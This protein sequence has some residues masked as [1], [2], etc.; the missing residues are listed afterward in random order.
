MQ[1][2]FVGPLGAVTG[3]CTWLEHEG[4]EFLVDCG[5]EQEDRP[6]AGWNGQ[7]WPF[8]P[9]QLSF[10]VLTHAHADHCGL[11]PELYRR[12]FHGR[13]LCTK[14]TAEIA[15]VMLTDSA[16][17]SNGRY[18]QFD[19]NAIQWKEPGR[20]MLGGYHP[21]AHDLFIQFFRTAH[22]IGAVSVRILW[23]D[24]TAGEQKSIIFSGDLG[25]D[26]EDQECLPFLRHRMGVP[27]SDFAVIEST[28]GSRERD[29]GAHG[30]DARRSHLKGLMDKIKETGGT[31]LIPA[32]SLGRTQDLLFDLHWLVAAN[33]KR[34]AQFVFRL[35][36]P[37]AEKLGPI[38]ANGLERTEPN[39]KGKIRP[40]WLGKQLFRWLGL[41]DAE[42]EDV[43]R[44][45]DICRVTLGLPIKYPGSGD[46]GNEIARGW[47]NLL[48][49]ITD[50]SGSATPEK[51]SKR[52]E[53]VVATSGMGDHGRSASWVRRLLRDPDSVIAFSG[54]CAASS[55]GGKLLTLAKASVSERRRSRENLSW[56]DGTSIP[57]RDVVAM[58]GAL[59]GYS[60]H[61]DQAGLVAWTFSRYNDVT[62]P[63]GRVMFIQHGNEQERKALAQAIEKTGREHGIDVRC[64]R[65]MATDEAYILDEMMVTA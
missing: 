7:P 27:P 52:P 23:G 30:L 24:R 2:R 18:T 36:A 21:V 26:A 44:A 3:S 53:V 17:L 42:V 40:V 46:R 35:D 20:P 1:V 39:G 62:T 19:V 8:E 63:A 9:T 25:P 58:I 38:L 14:E 51:S 22:I 61:A 37:L 12:G 32:F 13:V 16:R 59:H 5:L 49:S 10:V 29:A 6:T 50:G 54:Y 34:Y 15:K 33:P 41:D 56:L 48:G 57:E 45:I 28:Y 55:I 4:I 11:I 43:N 65:P 60:A 64:V 47:P 31:L